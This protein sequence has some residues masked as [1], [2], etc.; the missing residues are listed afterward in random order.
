MNTG[1]I[2]KG[3]GGFYY[4]DTNEN[5]IECK[6]RGHFRNKKLSPCVG[7]KVEITI[8]GDG[9]GTIDVI[10]ERKNVFVRPPVS[11]I[12][13]MIIVASV[14]NTS[15]DLTFIDKMLVIAHNCDVDV[16]ICFNK[17]DLDDGNVNSIVQMYRDAGYDAFTTSTVENVG[18]DIIRSSIKGKTVAFSGFSGV[19]KSSLL[20]A[21]LD[22]D[23]MQTGEVSERLKRGKHT[24]RHVELYPLS[25]LFGDGTEGYVADTPGFSLLDFVRFDFFDKEDLLYTFPEFDK[26][27]GGCRYTRCTHL[28]ED[29]CAIYDAVKRG[30]IVK[31]R[32][33]SFVSIYNDLK[34]KNK[35]DK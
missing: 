18:I 13:E 12:D 27:I 3:I 6:A 1:T 14:S 31:S 19:G 15:P 33:D 32:H 35:W 4:V 24:T 9:K 8:D 20:N 28:C 17:S 21:A 2:V 30:E 16:K 5:I 11:N 29:G 25:E 23:V 7:D 22:N 26:Y 10:N 34:G